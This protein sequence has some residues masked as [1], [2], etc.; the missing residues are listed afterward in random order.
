MWGDVGSTDNYGAL[1]STYLASTYE[2]A[3]PE[4]FVWTEFSER[5]SAW[6]LPYLALIMQLPF[7]ATDTFD[8]VV[9]VLLS[10]G[11][12]T[13]AAYSLALTVLNG[14]WIAR[15]F[16]KISYPNVRSAVQVMRRLQQVP[17]KIET[18]GGVLVSLVVLPENDEWWTDIVGWLDY[19]HTFSMSSIA[20][21]SW[22]TIAFL[23][24][25][26]DS[27]TETIEQ[28]T[29]NAVGQ[30]V[31]S[32]Y[33]SL[34]PVVIGWLQVDPKCDSRR[35]HQAIDRANKIAYIAARDGK[36]IL[37]SEALT[38]HRAISLRKH[39]GSV[40]RDEQPSAP[41]YN[42][43]R[44]FGWVQ[45]V[46]EVYRVFDAASAH[47]EDHGSVDP[48]IPWALEGK[49]NK[50]KGRKKNHRG[51]L[52]QVE[53][54]MRPVDAGRMSRSHW[55]P[56]VFSRLFVSSL[57]ALCLTWATVGSAAIVVWFI[58]TQCLGC[59]SGAYLLYGALST[60]VWMM[61]VTSSALAHY[62][63]HVAHDI[64]GKPVYPTSTRIAGKLSII[65][66]RLGKVIA[67][68]NAV[69]IILACI[70]QFSSFFDRYYCNRSLLGLG[71]S[72]YCVMQLVDADISPMNTA[73]IGGVAL[74]GGSSILFVVF[75][76][77]FMNPPLPPA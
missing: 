11:S 2:M 44:F 77:I 73:R 39:R 12:P 60:V 53:Q 47:A 31:G 65:L 57:F 50:D 61:L 62:S 10:V 56:N 15:R 3:G 8:N 48:P 41:I 58:P 51:T 36:S 17:V 29:L 54:Y 25:V 7:D 46:E 16:S 42:Y 13:L 32:V 4:P 52:E 45:A 14:R 70:F 19:T 66:R 22:A 5:F 71:R 74:A 26:V 40:H 43:A 35:L 37:A 24:T 21:I 6:L 18:R 34:L 30:G 27:F 20:S 9:A 68:C 49:G 33:L 28:R 75:M 63:T 76:N 64:E 23:F 55:G 69:W 1:V 59:R 67:A 72:V 38:F